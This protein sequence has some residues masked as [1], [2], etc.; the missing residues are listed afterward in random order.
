MGRPV[1]SRDDDE[2]T[3]LEARDQVLTGAERLP[4]ILVAQLDGAVL[5]EIASGRERVAFA[6]KDDHVDLALLR[7]LAHA[8]GNGRDHGERHG[9]S[10]LW[11]GQHDVTD[12]AIGPDF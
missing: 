6:R 12:R 3:V 11:T 1:N 4:R 5:A 10:L 9:V 8:V 7:E 2:W